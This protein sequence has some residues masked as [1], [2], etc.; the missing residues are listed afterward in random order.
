MQ[1]II[2]QELKFRALFAFKLN[3]CHYLFLSLISEENQERLDRNEVPYDGWYAGINVLTTNI[4]RGD[5]QDMKRIYQELKQL[6]SLVSS[7]TRIT[8]HH[9]EEEK[10]KRREEKKRGENQTWRRKIWQH[11]SKLCICT[12]FTSSIHYVFLSH[13]TDVLFIFVLLGKMQ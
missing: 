12:F 6:L 10:R 3:V 8:R 13:I 11:Y 1:F 7:K 4:K 5:H 9:R 2:S